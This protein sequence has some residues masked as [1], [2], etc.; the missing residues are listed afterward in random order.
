MH[1]C[2]GNGIL[3]LRACQIYMLASI[4]MGFHDILQ[5]IS[6]VGSIF[7]ML[8]QRVPSLGGFQSDTSSEVLYL[9]MMISLVVS[10]Y[11][12]L[13]VGRQG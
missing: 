11:G 1:W 8:Y 10:S 3:H 6:F 12:P 5:E 7:R 2:G 4:F 9:H 13:A